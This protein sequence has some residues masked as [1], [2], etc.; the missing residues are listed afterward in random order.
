MQAFDSSKPFSV[1]VFNDGGPIDK[2]PWIRLGEF[3]DLSEAIS[4]S[5]MII[6]VFLKEHSPFSSSA[7]HLALK[8]LKQGPM[9]IINGAK[10]LESFDAYEYLDRRCYEV[11]KD[12]LCV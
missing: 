8:Y 1:D 6:D 11:T 12:R 2:S 3:D 9:P 4:T 5:K 10:N 7:N